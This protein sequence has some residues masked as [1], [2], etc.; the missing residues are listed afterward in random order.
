M[1]IIAGHATIIGGKIYESPVNTLVEAL[2]SNGD[3]FLFIRHY[4][5]GELPS[6]VY[7]L[8]GGVVHQ[9]FVLKGITRLAPLRYISEVLTTCWYFWRHKPVKPSYFIGVD[10]LNALSGI[11]LRK[12]GIVDKAVYFSVDYAKKRFSNGIL[13]FTYHF[14]DRCVSHHADQVWC[15]SARIQE[16][17]SLMGLPKCKNLLLPNVPSMDYKPY[18]SNAR[19]KYRLI[20][21]GIISNQLDFTGILDAL[22]LLKPEYPELEL[23]IYGDGPKK[24]AHE[25]YAIEKGLSGFVFFY[26]SVSHKDALN[27]ISRSGI[28][29]ALYNGNW[30][31]N[32]YGDSMKCREYFCFGLPV[33]TTDTH[34]TVEDIR[35]SGAGV[36]VE[37]SAESYANAVRNII[38]SYSSYSVAASSLAARY[39]N[40]HLKHLL[41]LVR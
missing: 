40:T 31:F 16:V 22:V 24:D 38:G 4:M 19:N 39:D 25:K 13:N 27:A 17:R 26:G 9:D 30:G 37:I 21:L 20:T 12:F 35:Q 29:L 33:I 23:H 3:K 15:V 28:G 32:Y 2:K 5:G 8:N 14:I 10:P 36:V 6:S 34:S 7:S 41:A 18:V 1:F 11:L